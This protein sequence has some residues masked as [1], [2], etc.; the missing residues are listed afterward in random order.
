[1]YGLNKFGGDVNVC[2]IAEKIRR[3]YK[4]LGQN[5]VLNKI[6]IFVM[7]KNTLFNYVTKLRS[8]FFNVKVISDLNANIKFFTDSV[9][10][11]LKHPYL[12]V[13]S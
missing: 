4:R 11:T 8:I 1:M 9:S 13:K 6:M 7:K 2:K 5:N 10:V 12:N 3:N